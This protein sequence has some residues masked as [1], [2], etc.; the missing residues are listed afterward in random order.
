MR[1][2]SVLT[3]HVPFCPHRKQR[4]RRS[5]AGARARVSTF[6]CTPPRWCASLARWQPC[7]AHTPSA[8][9]TPNRTSTA[10]TPSL[11]SSCASLRLRSTWQ[12][13]MRFGCKECRRAA[14]GVLHRYM[15]LPAP[16]SMRAASSCCWCALLRRAERTTC[17][18][19]IKLLWDRASVACSAARGPCHSPC[20]GPWPTAHAHIGLVP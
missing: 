9:R 10:R 15:A 16:A 14:G 18:A 19:A 17:H 2:T 8:S 5:F 6:G 3:V 13:F 12:A 20:F 4:R 11:G 1:H 7:F